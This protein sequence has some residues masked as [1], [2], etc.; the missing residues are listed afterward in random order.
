MVILL[1]LLVV[2]VVVVIVVVV[3]VVIVAVD[4]M[5]LLLD[6]RL[7]VKLVAH[8]KERAGCWG[9]RGRCGEI[10]LARWRLG[11]FEESPIRISAGLWGQSSRHHSGAGRCRGLVRGSSKSASNR[12]PHFESAFGGDQKAKRVARPVFHVVNPEVVARV[13][14]HSRST[15]QG[16]SA[17]AERADHDLVEEA[18]LPGGCIAERM[19]RGSVAAFGGRTPG[20]KRHVPHKGQRSRW[21]LIDGSLT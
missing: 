3:V 4:M 5:I 10:G 17:V 2:V 16:R 19:L 12:F 13:G 14:A 11:C 6:W 7:E 20:S 1:L 15:D 8:A 18:A 9:A 21:P